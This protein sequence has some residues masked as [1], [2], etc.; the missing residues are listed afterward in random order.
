MIE[1]YKAYHLS[2]NPLQLLTNHDNPRRD[3][4]FV[5]VCRYRVFKALFHHLLQLVTKHR[6]SLTVT[7]LDYLFRA[8]LSKIVRICARV[9][10]KCPTAAF[11]GQ[12]VRMP[13]L[14]FELSN[15]AYVR[16]WCMLREML[17]TGFTCSSRQFSD[18]GASTPSL[19]A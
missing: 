6:D 17:L 2:S 4:N 3:S 18:E 10:H 19:Y 15:C 9:S 5:V 14:R 1:L 7:F 16:G 12:L 13:N 11:L 8:R